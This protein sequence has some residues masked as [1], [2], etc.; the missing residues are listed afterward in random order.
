MQ[1]FMNSYQLHL[2]HQPLRYLPKAY[3]FV[4]YMKVGSIMRVDTLTHGE[5]QHVLPDSDSPQPQ[6]FM[7]A[8]FVYMQET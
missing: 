3:A 4:C 5:I 6:L 2:H 8:D 1:R 7:C